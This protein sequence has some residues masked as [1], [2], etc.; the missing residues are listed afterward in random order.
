MKKIYILLTK[1]GTVV[2]RLVSLFTRD[3][4]TH[5]SISFEENLQPLY[6]SSRK[7]GE[8]ML[9]AGP[10]VENFYRGYLKKHPLIPCSLYELVVSDEVYEKAKRETEVII[11]NADRYGYNVLGMIFCGMNIKVKRRR[12][13]FC[14]QFVS[15]ILYN[16]D[17]LKLPKDRNL[18][19]PSDYMKIPELNCLFTGTLKDLIN[20]YN[21]VIC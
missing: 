2:S 3:S 17:A 9:P 19:R 4:Y 5:V 20:K 8:T 10:C 13:Y 16:S 7:N 18:M 1:S 11:K 15:E 14:S 6:S 21:R 12:S